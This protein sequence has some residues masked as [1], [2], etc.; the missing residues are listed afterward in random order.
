MIQAEIWGGISWP[1]IALPPEGLNKTAVESDPA[2][3]GWFHIDNWGCLWLAEL[4]N[5]YMV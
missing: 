2:K 3:R 5:I 4:Y 1:R